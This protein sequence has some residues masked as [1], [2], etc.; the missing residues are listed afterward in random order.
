MSAM[1]SLVQEV[2]EIVEESAFRSEEEILNRVSEHFET[3]PEFR[4]F[5]LELARYEF[6]VIENDLK[7]FFS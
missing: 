6:T 7:G 4:K 2:Q 5:A 1:S 3:R